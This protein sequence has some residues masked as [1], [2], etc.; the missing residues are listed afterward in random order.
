[1]P[2]KEFEL[3]NLRLEIVKN[4]FDENF[5]SIDAKQVAIYE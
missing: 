4:F 3:I 2:I 1:M 5:K